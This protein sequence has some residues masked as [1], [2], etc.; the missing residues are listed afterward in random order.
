MSQDDKVYYL[1]CTFCNCIFQHGGNK[2]ERFALFS[3]LVCLQNLHQNNITKE[4]VIK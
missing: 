2:E 3:V 4:S 1:C